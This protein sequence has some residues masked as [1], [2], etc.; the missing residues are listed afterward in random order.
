MRPDYNRQVAREL[1]K[2]LREAID[3]VPDHIERA[4]EEGPVINLICESLGSAIAAVNT[5]VRPS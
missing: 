1:L 5:V 2:Q 3:R 4:P